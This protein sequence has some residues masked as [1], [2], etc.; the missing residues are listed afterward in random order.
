MSSTSPSSVGPWIGQNMLLLTGAPLLAATIYMTFRHVVE[1]LEASK[2][3]IVSPR[4]ITRFYV[5]LDIIVIITQLAG[6]IMPASGD[7]HL[8]A[9]SRKI[10]LAGLSIQLA[11]LTFFMANCWQVH[12]KL[13]QATKEGTMHGLVV[14]WQ[15][16]LMALEAAT[17]L[18]FIRSMVR[19]VE[20]AQGDTGY[21]ASHEVYI[22]VFD[23]ALM[24]LI[25]LFFSILHP[26]RLVQ[27]MDNKEKKKEGSRMEL[28]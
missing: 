25:M 20:Y 27:D 14:S 4:W 9:L 24:F 11:A 13:R 6:T 26:Q 2:L 12:K 18:L 15:T 23:G 22:Y 1:A 10:I 3:A 21:V 5:L 8:I 7:A 16:H 28:V 19:V 17:L